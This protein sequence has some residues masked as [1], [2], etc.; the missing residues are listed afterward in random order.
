MRKIILYIAILFVAALNAEEIAWA[1]DFGTGIER[2]AKE[3]KPVLFVISKHTCPPC[4]KMAETTF[5]DARFVKSVN[6]SFVPIIAYLDERDAM[7][8][9]LFLGVT[10]T[11]WFLNPDGTPMFEA[12]KGAPYTEN[13]LYYLGVVK[14]EFEKPEKKEE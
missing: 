8:R 7:P 9:E 11:I 6:E 3:D 4:K 12:I 13:F 1:K 14:T 10:P 2:A 5:K